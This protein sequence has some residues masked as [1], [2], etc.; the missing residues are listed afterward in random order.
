[1][2]KPKVRKRD[3]ERRKPRSLDWRPGYVVGK[4]KPR[5]LYPT[6]RDDGRA[7]TN[8]GRLIREAEREREDEQEESSE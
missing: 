5:E 3:R 6:K 2:G 8:L 4:V 7:T 1:M